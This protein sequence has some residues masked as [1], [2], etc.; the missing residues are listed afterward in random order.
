MT[1]K[2]SKKKKDWESPKIR[3]IDIKTDTGGMGG[4]GM[5]MGMGPPVS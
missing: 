4:N 2:T 5:G 1:N 3:V